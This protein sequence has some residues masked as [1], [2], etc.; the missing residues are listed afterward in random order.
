MTSPSK[1]KIR[2]YYEDTDSGGVVYYANY[3][4]HLE[5]ARTEFLRERGIELTELIR[6]GN[7]FVVAHVDL[8]YRHPARYNDLLTVESRLETSG[9]AS[10]VFSHKIESEQSG[11]IVAEG[12]ITLVCVGENGKPKRLPEAVRRIAGAAGSNGNSD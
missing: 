9:Q 1:I 3:L 5:R 8:T 10:V 2:I 6:D 11:R 4:R 7:L 12:R